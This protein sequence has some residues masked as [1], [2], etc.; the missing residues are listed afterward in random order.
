VAYFF[1]GHPVVASRSGTIQ[2]ADL[3]TPNSSRNTF[4]GLFSSLLSSTYHL[5]DWGFANS[6]DK[7][8]L[9]AFVCRS[10]RLK[11]YQQTI[12]L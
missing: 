5:Y 10:V 3:W 2:D 1:G 4:W 6:S 8:R 11:L 12:P 7:D 9:D